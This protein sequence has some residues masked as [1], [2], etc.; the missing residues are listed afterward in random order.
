MCRFKLIIFYRDSK[1]ISISIHH[2]CRFKFWD[3]RGLLHLLLISIHH[4]CRFKKFYTKGC[5]N[6]AKFQ[7]IICVGSRVNNFCIHIIAIKFQYII[8]VGSSNRRKYI[9]ITWHNFN[10]SY[11]SV[12][13]CRK[14][15]TSINGNLFQ[16]IIC[17]GSSNLLYKICST[18]PYF[19]TSYVSVQVINHKLYVLQNVI[20]IH[21]MCRFK[22]CVVA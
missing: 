8:C 6:M 22:L 11:V 16:Y 2:M 14:S 10:T 17:V 19:N 13:A 20:S 5:K 21:H 3:R 9:I 18:Y 15:L 4:M 1:V 7:Y 12:Q